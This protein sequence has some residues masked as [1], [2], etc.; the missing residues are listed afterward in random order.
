MPH[1]CLRAAGWRASCA[2]GAK[3]QRA[4]RPASTRFI[5]SG[6]GLAH[7]AGAQPR[8]DVAEREC[9]GRSTR[10]PSPSRWSCRPARARHP[11]ARLCSTWSSRTSRRAVSSVRSWFGRIMSRSMSGAMPKTASTW[12]SMWRCCAVASTRHFEPRLRLQR[13]DHRRHLH[14]FGPRAHHADDLALSG[15]SV[16]FASR[17]WCGIHGPHLR[18]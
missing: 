18:S 17:Y 5:S 7:V 13:E 3:C 15:H 9:A 4:R 6:N 16:V 11:A 10:A 12:S 14:R 2:V 8:L 1:R